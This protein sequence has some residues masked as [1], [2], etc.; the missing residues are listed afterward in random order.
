FEFTQFIKNRKWIDEYQV[1]PAGNEPSTKL[2]V[3]AQLPHFLDSLGYWMVAVCDFI[4]FGRHISVYMRPYQ[5]VVFSKLLHHGGRLAT[6]YSI[7]SSHL[8]ASLPGN[9]YQQ[10]F[11]DNMLGK[12]LYLP[13]V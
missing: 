11:I 8:V 10:C 3:K 13:L 1:R 7:N 6:K 12:T 5:A 2:D 4:K 9:F